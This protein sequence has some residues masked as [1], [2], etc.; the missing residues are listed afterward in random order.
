MPVAA[1][2]THRPSGDR[3]PIVLFPAW[4]FTRLTVSVR[5]QRVDSDCPR[6][7][8]FE[9]LVFFD[10]GP[11]FS[12]VCRDELLTLRYDKKSHR[13]MRR[14][15]SEPRGVKVTVADYGRTSSAPSYE[16]M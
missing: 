3:T 10:P 16:A 9:D 15:F 13:P 5:N 2:V 6:S 1:T 7:G 12:Q 4:H 14:R 8:T 11:P